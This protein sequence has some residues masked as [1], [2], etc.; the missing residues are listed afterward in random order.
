MRD[1]KLQYA[2]PVYNYEELDNI[3]NEETQFV[4]NDQLF[5]DTLLMEIKGDS[6]SYASFKDKQ[7][8]NR[9]SFLMK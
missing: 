3:P 6:I 2:L 7:R 8:N 5:L 4:I 1:I 9:E